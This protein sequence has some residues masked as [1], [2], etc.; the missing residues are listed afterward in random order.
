[1]I[2]RHIRNL[3]TRNSSASLVNMFQQWKG[4]VHIPSHITP[5]ILLCDPPDQSTWMFTESLNHMGAVRIRH[6]IWEIA[7][8]PVILWILLGGKPKWLP[9]NFA[10]NDVMR[11]A[12]TG[13]EGCC[14][15]PHDGT[16]QMVSSTS[17]C[18]AN[19][20]RLRATE[21]RKT[22]QVLWHNSCQ[23]WW[24]R[25]RERERERESQREGGTERER[26]RER[27]RESTKGEERKESTYICRIG[28]NDHSDHC[29][30]FAFCGKKQKCEESRFSWT[31]PNCN[32]Y[33]VGH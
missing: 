24:E 6:S 21:K 10:F 23:K 15:M 4:E 33:F 2:N 16:A 9:L 29:V 32:S 14:D 8:Q 11:T 12:T 13:P 3:Y 1:M 28:W 30:V 22:A 20:V 7:T 27:E 5:L 25:E 31:A 17:K 18:N 19:E 26:E